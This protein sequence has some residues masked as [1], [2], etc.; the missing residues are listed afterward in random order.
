MTGHDEG[1]RAD[2]EAGASPYVVRRGRSRLADAMIDIKATRADSGGALTVSEFTLP[3]WSPG[4]VLHLHEAVDE[5]LYVLAGRLDVQLG[6]VRL[7]LEPG[8]F[9]W[10]PRGVQHAFASA[11]DVEARALALAVPGGLEDMFREQAAQLASADG[12]DPAELDRIGR[13]HGARTLGP[14][15]E[16]RRP[17]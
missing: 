1:V 2:D 17:G 10:M 12:I 7:Y 11:S 3:A 16:P 15:L 6:D 13:R 8:D 14:P 5:A 4:P 9:V